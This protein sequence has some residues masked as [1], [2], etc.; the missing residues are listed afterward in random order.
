MND[1]SLKATEKFSQENGRR[2]P[3]EILCPIKT[4]YLKSHDNHYPSDR[5]V[6]QNQQ[7]TLK[8]EALQPMAAVRL[9][10]IFSKS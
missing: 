8:T 6:C 4:G 3:L 10:A 7:N 9:V 1:L 5:R 2:A